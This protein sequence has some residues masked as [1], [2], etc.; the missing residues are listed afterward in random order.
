MLAQ[1]NRAHLSP[2]ALPAKKLKKSFFF[3]K[4]WMDDEW[5]SG[6]GGVAGGQVCFA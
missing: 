3:E 6:G 5:R 4:C 1:A 2:R